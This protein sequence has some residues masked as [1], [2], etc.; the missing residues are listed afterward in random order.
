MSQ[1]DLQLDRQAI[2]VDIDLVVRVKHF[3][4]ALD[5]CQ[6][7][8]DVTDKEVCAE[9]DID[10]A[11]WSRIKRTGDPDYA[12]QKAYFPHHKLIRFMRLCGNRAPLIW[13]EHQYG[14]DPRSVRRYQ[15]ETEA[16]LER[17][18]ARSRELEQQLQTI[19]EFLQKVKP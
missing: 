14:D 8:G 16:A 3:G 19:T 2:E 10:P 7:I 4:K 12:G 18:Q 1:V 15:S 9:L 17:E 6:T 11:T 5:L 13:L